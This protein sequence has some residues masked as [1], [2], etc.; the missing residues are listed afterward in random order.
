MANL[1][2]VCDDRV[3][4]DSFKDGGKSSD[5]EK[6]RAGIKQLGGIISKERFSLESGCLPGVFLVACPSCCPNYCSI[7]NRTL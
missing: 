2:V 6:N 3:F 7:Y 5:R 4:N 1:G